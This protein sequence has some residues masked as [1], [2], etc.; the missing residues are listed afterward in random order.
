MEKLV[1]IAAIMTAPRHEIVLSRN[2]I[3]AAMRKMQIPLTISGGVF[4][5]Q[6]MQTMLAD[7]VNKNV[8]YALTVDFD[9][10]FLAEHVQRLLNIIAHDDSVDAI[11]AVQPK[12]GVG[13]VL[14]SRQKQESIDWDGKPI[15]VQSAHFGLT[16][17]DLDKLRDVPKPWFLAVPNADGEWEGDKI[18][19]D[20]Y[21]WRAW[22]KAGNTIYID[23]GC[24]LGH[25]EEM[26]TVYDEKLQLRHYYPKEWKEING[27]TVD[28]AVEKVPC[29]EAVSADV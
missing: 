23:P 29:G 25:L 18:D 4:Y 11:T 6:C 3:E 20:V 7:L 1:S 15:Q 16:I 2:Y 10:M 12:R 17:I 9:S 14:A 22:E 21:F 19:D 27:S 8:K 24:R 13:T 28:Q 5:G 26:V